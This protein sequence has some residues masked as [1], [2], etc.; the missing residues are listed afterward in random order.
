MDVNISDL[1]MSLSDGGE[2]MTMLIG[3]FSFKP[4]VQEVINFKFS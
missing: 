3:V 4:N 1:V 2:L